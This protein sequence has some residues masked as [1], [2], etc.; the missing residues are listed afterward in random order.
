[1]PIAAGA[2]VAFCRLIEAE[3]IEEQQAAA[4]EFV[5]ERCYHLGHTR[6]ET[7]SREA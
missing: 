7:K 1:V 4:E 3:G 5:V 2:A 6:S